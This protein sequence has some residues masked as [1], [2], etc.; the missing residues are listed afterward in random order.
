MFLGGKGQRWGIRILGQLSSSHL[1]EQ[2]SQM[3][4]NGLRYYLQQAYQSWSQDHTHLSHQKRQNR[5]PGSTSAT[6]GDTMWRGLEAAPETA[7]LC[8]HEHLELQP[9]PGG[10][11]LGPGAGG[12]LTLAHGE[13]QAMPTPRSLSIPPWAG[14]STSRM[15]L[16]PCQCIQEQPPTQPHLMARLFPRAISPEEPHK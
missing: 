16:A 6:S 13:S 8:F 11:E 5:T 10:F 1:L 2:V 9:A 15:L 4:P 14:R 3:L 12:L 7:S